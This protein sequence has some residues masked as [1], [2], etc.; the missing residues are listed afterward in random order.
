MK[1][2]TCIPIGITTPSNLFK[3]KK[4]K[5]NFSVMFMNMML[6]IILLSGSTSFAQSPSIIAVDDLF[7]NNKRSTS[8]STLKKVESLLKTSQP[9]THLSEG[10]MVLSTK[11]PVCVYTDVSSLKQ[12]NLIEDKGTV[13]SISIH[14]RNKSELNQLAS[15]KEMHQ[16]PRLKVIK[17]N[18]E[19]DIKLNEF[20]S[21]IPFHEDFSWVIVYEV[22]KPS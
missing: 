4:L 5:S 9:S 10:R 11:R 14:L 7:S 22:I 13:E 12:L 17:L 20:S 8:N 21:L 16:F 2:I 1:K 19:F 15:L 18:F 3:M 6:I